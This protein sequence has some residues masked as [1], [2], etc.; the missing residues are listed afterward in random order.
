MISSEAI[1]IIGEHLARAREWPIDA[2]EPLHADRRAYSN[3]LTCRVRLRD[4]TERLVFVKFVSGV[5]KDRERLEQLVARDYAVTTHLHSAFQAYPQFDVPR[6]LAYSLRHLMLISEHVDGMRLQDK[7][8]SKARLYPRVETMA[9]LEKNCFSCGEWLRKFQIATRGFS[10][11]QAPLGR[12]DV[13]DAPAILRMLVE[14]IEKLRVAGVIDDSLRRIV[15]AFAESSARSAAADESAISGVHADFF[16]G[17]LL[18]RDTTVI[19]IDFVMFRRGSQYFD[20]AYFVFQLETLASQPLFRRRVVDRLK[21][22]FLKGYDAGLVASDFWT[23]SPLRNLL[24]L[25]HATSRL[26]ALSTRRPPSLLRRR[27]ASQSL[28]SIKARIMHHVR[29]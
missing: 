9:D 16:P 2:I 8:I 14:R 13:L 4:G 12:D 7:I 26:I 20:P 19:G 17:N 5:S 27:M 11:H 25:A 23:S 29:S 21:L 18:I 3:H 10:L 6:P 22:A 24:F 28:G 1:P 15:L